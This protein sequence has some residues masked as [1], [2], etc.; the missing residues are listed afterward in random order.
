MSVDFFPQPINK[1]S[2]SVT[3][4][5]YLL[6]NLQNALCCIHFPLWLIKHTISSPQWYQQCS[7]K[8]SGG[9]DISISSATDTFLPLVNYS[10]SEDFS[11]SFGKRI[12]ELNHLFLLTFK[13]GPRT[14]HPWI[15]KEDSFSIYI[16]LTS[17]K[18]PAC[19]YR[20]YMRCEFNP[21]VSKIPWRKKWQ[22]APVFLPGESHGQRS[23]MGYSLESRTES[24]VTEATK[25]IYIYIHI[26]Y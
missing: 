7:E 15:P 17:G 4:F 10:N 12:A 23:L 5:L 2:N 9:I 19:Q 1:I 18:E 26:I 11:S 6:T 21:W 8:T 14:N 16:W 20:R 22:P 13:V 24:D 3:N 25:Q